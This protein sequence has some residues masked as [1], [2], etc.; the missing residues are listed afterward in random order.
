[1]APFLI[2]LLMNI[3]A[4]AAINTLIE[5]MSGGRSLSQSEKDAAVKEMADR[6]IDPVIAQEIANST[7]GEHNYTAAAISGGAMGGLGYGAGKVIGKVGGDILG[8]LSPKS[9]AVGTEIPSGPVHI[10]EIVDEFANFRK[11]MT[12]PK[13]GMQ[14]TQKQLN[15]AAEVPSAR[16]EY[17]PRASPTS[18]GAMEMGYSPPESPI[19]VGMQAQDSGL[20]TMDAVKALLAKTGNAG[21]VSEQSARDMAY[22]QLAKQKSKQVSGILSKKRATEADLKKQQMDTLW[23]QYGQ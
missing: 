8:K 20:P 11:P 1:M 22:Q 15:I 6:G 14:S 16:L 7:K 12:T 23:S 19:A 4:G 2:P 3:G 17:T 21:M 9:A 18:R 10:P 13:L 5:A